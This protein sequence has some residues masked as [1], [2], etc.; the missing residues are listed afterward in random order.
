MDNGP[1]LISM[2][3]ET[4]TNMQEEFIEYF[5]TENDAS[6]VEENEE[7]RVINVYPV[8]IPETKE[9]KKESEKVDAQPYPK[10]PSKILSETNSLFVPKHG[11]ASPVFSGKLSDLPPVFQ[12]EYLE[13]SPVFYYEH[14]KHVVNEN[15]LDKHVVN[16]NDHNN[17]IHITDEEEE[18]GINTS[19]SATSDCPKLDC[20]TYPGHVCCSPHTAS[21]RQIASHSDDK[22]H[23]RIT[24]TVTRVV[25]SIRWS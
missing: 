19:Y 14:D 1:D 9:I 10:L 5:Q 11:E 24:S 12:P 2:M 8:F 21:K 17:D 6:E 4:T 22:D 23:H 18:N 25:K 16:G 3:Y 7:D 15:E 13:H 20:L